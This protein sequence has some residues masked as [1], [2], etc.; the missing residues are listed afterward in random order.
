MKTDQD[1]LLYPL[2]TADLPTC[3]G[4]GSPMVIALHE[5]R[6]NSPDF[7]TYRCD[8]CARSEKFICEE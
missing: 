7:S 6:K 2:T 8:Y 1:L 3:P 4:C 5:V